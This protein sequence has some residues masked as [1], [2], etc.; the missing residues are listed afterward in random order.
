MPPRANAYQR[1]IDV[2][3]ETVGGWMLFFCISMCVLRPVVGG[4]QIYLEVSAFAWKEANFPGR[5]LF[6]S[7]VGVELSVIAFGLVAGIFLW[8]LRPRGI[9]MAKTFL[10]VQ[11]LVPVLFLIALTTF[12]KVLG[13]DSAALVPTMLPAL[14]RALVYGVVWWLYL[15]RS[16]RVMRTYELVRQRAEGFSVESAPAGV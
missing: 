3:Y 14:G 13:G 16:H 2:D 15:S 7:A 1:A 11:F 6:A 8:R 9:W 12:V 10:L 5:L 4:F